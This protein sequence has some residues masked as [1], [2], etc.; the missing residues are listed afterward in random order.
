MRHTGPVRTPAAAI[1]VAAL[2][3]ALGAG[4]AS[5]SEGSVPVEVAD[6]VAAPDGLL[7][8]L[9]DF[10]GVGAD[11][12]GFDFGDT[13]TMGEID[14]VFVFAPDWLDS[15]TESTDAPAPVALSNEWT[16]AVSIADKPVGF[17][18]VWID[19]GSVRPELADFVADPDPAAALAAVPDG[20]NVVHDAA[21]GAWFLLAPP[22]LTPIVSGTSGVSGPTTLSFYRGLLAGDNPAPA[23]PGMNAGSV[24]SIAIIGA[25]CVAVILAL[26]I[27]AAWRRRREPGAVTSADAD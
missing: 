9:D 22:A 19:P 20:T 4:P 25:V 15:T 7:A 26:V 12:K 1:A 17:A 16:V 27:P 3:F 6:F 13:T 21:R 10:F 14:R 8:S 11:G 5:A 2:A 23:P 18:V 24:L